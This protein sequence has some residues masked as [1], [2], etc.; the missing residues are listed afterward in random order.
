MTEP[1]PDADRRDDRVAAAHD[2]LR[3]HAWREAFEHLRAADA[4]KPLAPEHLEALAETAL[5]VGRLD[6]AIAASERAHA[7]YLEHGNC[8]RAGFMAIWLGHHH[9]AKGQRSLG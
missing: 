5:S 9:F 8:R 2:A 4:S 7:G 1:A 6:D 3:R